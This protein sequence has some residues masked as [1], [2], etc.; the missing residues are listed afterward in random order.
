M[1]SQPIPRAGMGVRPSRDATWGQAP[2]SPIICRQGR[3]RARALSSEW[4]T[5]H[6]VCPR[7]IPM[8]P[9]PVGAPALPVFA[10]TVLAALRLAPAGEFSRCQEHSLQTGGAGP[11]VSHASLTDPERISVWRQRLGWG[12]AHHSGTWKARLTSECCEP[13]QRPGLSDSHTIVCQGFLLGCGA[14]VASSRALRPHT[15]RGRHFVHT[16]WLRVPSVCTRTPSSLG[17]KHSVSRIIPPL[18]PRLLESQLR[19]CS[20]PRRVSTI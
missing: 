15:T 16:P 2:T 9:C 19:T 18:H 20:P 8:R 6:W 10:V 13:T 7:H 4:G 5:P 3:R 1:C 11:S 12:P 14:I 17:N